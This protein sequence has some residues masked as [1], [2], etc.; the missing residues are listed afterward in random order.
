MPRQQKVANQ[1][2]AKSKKERNNKNVLQIGQ[3]FSLL[4]AGEAIEAISPGACIQL[5]GL[6]L[7]DKKYFW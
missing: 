6:F 3:S 2:E 4:W 5:L 7:N 1:D